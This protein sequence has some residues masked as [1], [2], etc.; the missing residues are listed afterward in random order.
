MKARASPSDA[1]GGRRVRAPALRIAQMFYDERCSDPL[2]SRGCGGAGTG[3]Q[4]RLKLCCPK[5]HVG[6]I[7][8]RRTSPAI[9]PGVPAR[10]HRPGERERFSAARRARL[11]RQ[12]GDVRG[13]RRD[14]CCSSCC[15]ARRLRADHRED[16][17]PRQWRGATHRG[18][19]AHRRDRARSRCTAIR[20]RS[21]SAPSCVAWRATE[22]PPSARGPVPS[23][24]VIR[25]TD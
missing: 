17:R 3:I 14:S 2:D 9:G 6:S 7:P 18:R 12:G 20:H 19:S 23:G 10:P 1:I 5:G 13:G 11:T 24:W 8:T 22:M 16:I 4:G 21:R 15:S 25:S